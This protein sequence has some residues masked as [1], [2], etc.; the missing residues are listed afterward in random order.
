MFINNG[1]GMNSKELDILTKVI[2]RTVTEKDLYSISHMYTELY[3]FF[4]S[5]ES[6]LLPFHM[7]VGDMMYAGFCLYSGVVGNEG[8]DYIEVIPAASIADLPIS[9]WDDI[10]VAEIT[11]YE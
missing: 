11:I 4:N 9:D 1:P 2:L 7:A 5:N 8:V 3:E 10:L 6:V